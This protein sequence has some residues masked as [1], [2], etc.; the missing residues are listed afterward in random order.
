MGG[1]APSMIAQLVKIKLDWPLAK[2]VHDYMLATESATPA[3]AMR[4]LIRIGLGCG[5]DVA[6][7]RE[8]RLAAAC[9]AKEAIYA[10]VRALFEA[11][12][13]EWEVPSA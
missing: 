2:G 9:E 12:R 10:R 4:E 11:M 13:S 5:P 6:A 8:A 1:L 3:D 7:V